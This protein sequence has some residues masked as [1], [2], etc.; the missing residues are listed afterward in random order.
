MTSPEIR[1]LRTAG[2]RHL[3][4]GRWMKGRES[5]QGTTLIR[6]VY[7]VPTGIP[8]QPDRNGWMRAEWGPFGWRNETRPVADVAS[9]LGE[10]AQ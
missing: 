2:Y 1:A 9:L 7:N 10:G 3:G 6:E 4:N 8:G 5:A